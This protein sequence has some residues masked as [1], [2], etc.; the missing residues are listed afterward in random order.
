MIL[1]RVIPIEL[2]KH[3]LTQIQIKTL[4]NSNIPYESFFNILFE[5]YGKCIPKVDFKIKAKTI[6]NPL[7]TK[8]VTKSIY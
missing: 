5:T 2:F 4:H 1:N 6:Q 7:I 8:G 3:K